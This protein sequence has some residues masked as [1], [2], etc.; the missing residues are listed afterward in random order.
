MPISTASAATSPPNGCLPLPPK[1]PSSSRWAIAQAKLVRLESNLSAAFYQSLLM[2][3]AACEDQFTAQDG[4][5]KPPDVITVR[6][7][8]VQRLINGLS[9]HIARVERAWHKALD[10]LQKLQKDRRRNAVRQSIATEQNQ[11]GAEPRKRP[12]QEEPI[13]PAAAPKP[14][15]DAAAMEFAA[16]NDEQ[17]HRPKNSIPLNRVEPDRPRTDE[18]DTASG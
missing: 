2:R 7:F 13:G 17:S 15:A 16:K 6:E 5:V 8:D 14:A 11:C 1:P 9:Q 4:T 3:A 10:T 18:A 12:P